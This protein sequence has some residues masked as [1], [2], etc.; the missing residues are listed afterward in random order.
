MPV[1]WITSQHVV[2]YMWNVNRAPLQASG[3]G[4]ESST[5]MI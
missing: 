3:G 5:V 4:Q 1:G 2:F